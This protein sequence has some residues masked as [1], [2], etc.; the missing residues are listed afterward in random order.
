M[1]LI[2]KLPNKK[3]ELSYI[4]FLLIITLFSLCMGCDSGWSIGGLYL[5]GE[6]SSYI[7]IVSSD[8]ISHLYEEILKFGE[9]MWCFKHAQWE[10]VEVK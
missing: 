4:S 8:S 9:D 5:N 1:F 2:K 6:D 3:T 10:V 7:E